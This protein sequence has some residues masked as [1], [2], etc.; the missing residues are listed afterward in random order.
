MPWVGAFVLVTHI[1]VLAIVPRSEMVLVIP[2]L[3][4]GCYLLYCGFAIRRH[5]RR[6][7][8]KDKRFQH[9]FNAEISDGGIQIATPFSDSSMKWATFVRFLESDQ[10]FM[11]F[12]A[13]WMFL[14]FPKRAFVPAEAELFR[15]QLQH[16]ICPAKT[17]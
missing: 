3:L 7:F 5:F 14:V 1:A 4:V 13:E 8:Q 16:N 11:V 12:I 10:I 6:L 15:A 17:G 9:E 2:G